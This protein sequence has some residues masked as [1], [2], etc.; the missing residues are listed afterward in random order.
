MPKSM[1]SSSSRSYSILG[2]IAVARSR[3]LVDCRPQNPSIATPRSVRC[4]GVMLSESGMRRCDCKNPLA[5]RSPVTLRIC[6]AKTGVYSTQCPS[7]STTGC[8]RLLR[9]SWG[10]WCALIWLLPEGRDG[11]SS[12]R[13]LQRNPSQTAESRRLNGHRATYRRAIHDVRRGMRGRATLCRPKIVCDG[14]VK[15]LMEVRIMPRNGDADLFA[16]LRKIDTP[17]IT[18]VVATYPTNPVCLGL[19]NPWSENWYTDT[20]I[21]CMYPEL[22]AVAGYAVTCV[23][24]VP[25]PNYNRLTFMDVIDAL[26][27]SPKPT[28]LVLQQKF[29]PEL[30]AKA[31]L[32]GELMV[33]SMQAVGCV[34]MVSNGPSRDIDA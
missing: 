4:A 7:P 9:I 6:S 13:M 29:P 1:P 11:I 25:D 17:S 24:S 22:G 15:P 31:G 3:V 34:G 14:C 21:R 27:A 16:E 18:N 32:A 23:Y 26:D 20:S 2:I 8:V 19:Y 30:A 5:P 33:T 12:E 28:I 10:V